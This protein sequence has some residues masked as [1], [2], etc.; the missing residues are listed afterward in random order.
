M[1]KS[2]RAR[3]VITALIPILAA[4]AIVWSHDDPLHAPSR[5]QWKDHAIA[6]IQSRLEDKAWLQAALSR[7]RR[8]ASTQPSSITW[9]GDE[10][11]VL[12]NG[13]WI[14]CQ[15]VCAKEQNTAVKNDLFI[16]FGSD[17]R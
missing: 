15:S 12:K 1:N 10:L 5:R 8:A 2:H 17:G 14:L 9:I 13:D 16:G 4:C 7:L 3:I 6:K 11:I